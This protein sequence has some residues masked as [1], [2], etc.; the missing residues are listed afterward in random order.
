MTTRIQ[1]NS[2]FLSC[3][4]HWSAIL[5]GLAAGCASLPALAIEDTGTVGDKRWE[6]NLGTASA[7]TRSGWTIAAP[8]ADFNYGWGDNFQ[9]MAATAWV[10]VD[11]NGEKSKSGLGAAVIGGKWRFIDDDTTGFSMSTFPQYSQ[12][13]GSSAERRGIVEPG[14]H[15]FLPVALG[16]Q[17]GD[18]GTYGEIS[19]TFTR[20]GENEW[21]YGVKFLHQCATGI[22]CRLEL[23]RTHVPN[24]VRQTTVTAGF[25]WHLTQSLLLTGGIGREFGKS[26]DAQEN[27]LV[28]FGVQILR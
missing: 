11:D 2:R 28:Q 3:P 19:R 8:Q 20:Q 21:A 13:L 16:Y 18:L 17:Q 22:E 25:K 10:T 7:R 6:I 14:S 1:E 4:R 5:F 23:A 24:E 26:T 15:L 27:L 9:W 12:N